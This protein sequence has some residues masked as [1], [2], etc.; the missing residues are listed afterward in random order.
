MTTISAT[1]QFYKV[2]YPASAFFMGD[3]CNIQCSAT[4][5]PKREEME[6]CVSILKTFIALQ[7]GVTI[8]K[9]MLQ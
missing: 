7:F 4:T 6:D 2:M 1:T 5:F 9:V 8:R 3:S